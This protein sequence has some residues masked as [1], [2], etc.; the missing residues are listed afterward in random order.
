MG[1]LWI[2]ASNHHVGIIMCMYV[3]GWCSLRLVRDLA[4]LWYRQGGQGDRRMGKGMPC[5]FQR[6]VSGHAGV[7]IG[8][9]VRTMKYKDVVSASASN[10]GSSMFIGSLST[11]FERRRPL[12]IFDIVRCC[13]AWRQSGYWTKVPFSYG[14]PHPPAQGFWLLPST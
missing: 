12:R 1:F 6:L 8:A 9:F 3:C 5:C 11:S 7:I 4:S 2:Y 14:S 13:R 10:W